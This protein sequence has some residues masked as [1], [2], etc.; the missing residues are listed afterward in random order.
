MPRDV[1]T[2]EV[3]KYSSSNVT[4]VDNNFRVVGRNI[5]QYCIRC[6]YIFYS[7]N[8][9]IGVVEG[10]RGY[11]THTHIPEILKCVSGRIKYKHFV[12]V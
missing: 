9:T 4:I 1:L 6:K 5:T 2:V 10:I 3:G 11:T 12:N 8:K 7:L